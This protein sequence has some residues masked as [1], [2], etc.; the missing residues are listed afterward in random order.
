MRMGLED[1][2]VV[3]AQDGPNQILPLPINWFPFR[4]ISVSG[5]CV[6]TAVLT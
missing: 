1:E 2:H 3:P 6:R 5:R 4:L